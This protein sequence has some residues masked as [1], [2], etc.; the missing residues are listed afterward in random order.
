MIWN[1]SQTCFLIV[2]E[3]QNDFEAIVK[4]LERRF[5]A[6]DGVLEMLS[7]INEIDQQLEGADCKCS[8]QT[9]VAAE[10]IQTTRPSLEGEQAGPSAPVNTSTAGPT[11]ADEESRTTDQCASTLTAEPRRYK[12]QSEWKVAC[13]KRSKR[14]R[15][16][17]GW[18]SRPQEE[19]RAGHDLQ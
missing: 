14:R 8:A 11:S 9:A 4:H 17:H 18:G 6:R 7:L 19:R 13:G 10:S 15:E 16:E 1:Y 12:E 5:M 2:I 3:T